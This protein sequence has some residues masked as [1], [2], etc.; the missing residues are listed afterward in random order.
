MPSETWFLDGYLARHL[1]VDNKKDVMLKLLGGWL[2][3]WLFNEDTLFVVAV[4]MY[5]ILPRVKGA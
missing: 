1:G 2:V 3:Y 5:T 4:M